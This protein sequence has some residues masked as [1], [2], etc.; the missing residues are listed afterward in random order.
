MKSSQ[1]KLTK[2]F[3]NSVSKEWTER[4]YDTLGTF[5]KFPSNKA[6]ME[7]VLG[8]LRRLRFKGTIL[9]IGC[10][11][12]QLVIELLKMGNR[13][14]G[15]DISEKMIMGAKKNAA[16]IPLLRRYKEPLF[17]VMD[18]AHLEKSDKQYDASTALGLLEYL[19]TDGELFRSLQHVVAQGGYAFV[20]CRNKFFNL[21][22]ANAYT[23]SMAS[24]NLLP[25]LIE[26]FSEAGRYSL[27]LPEDIPK[28]QAEVSRNIGRFLSRAV[29]EKKWF[30]T[31]LPAYTGYPKEM[32]RRQ[33]TPQ[34]LECSARKYGF[35]VQYVI[36]WHAHP[37]PPSFEKR[38]P[39]IYNKIS[40]LM[41]PLGFTPLGAWMCSS[42]V[43]VLR[44][45]GE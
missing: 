11:E 31:T 35:E 34:E 16:I 3:F 4:T 2:D 37:Y 17:S 42:F 22:S 1:K 25:S 13:A 19:S 26:D 12:G 33:H 29:S 28:V 43:A 23:A 6:R 39:R 40:W 7:T 8:E 18:L 44:K 41:A 20:E 27:G 45:K 32:V 10:G 21:F 24:E 38:F 30:D 5:A 9:D 15:I 36:Y 14:S